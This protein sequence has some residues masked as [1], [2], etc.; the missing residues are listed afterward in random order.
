MK[1]HLAICLCLFSFHLAHAAEIGSGEIN[2]VK[3]IIDSRNY[4]AKSF[5][6]TLTL[7]TDF[8][9]DLKIPIVTFT[10]K[11]T[12][13]L[14]QNLHITFSSGQEFYKT[15]LENYCTQKLN[16]SIAQMKTKDGALFGTQVATN[17][18]WKVDRVLA[19]YKTEN[20]Q[21]WYTFVDCDI[22]N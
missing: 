12:S 1:L 6:G 17:T 9:T 7:E 11:E 22:R 14:I 18:P 10:T 20:G 19:Y 4:S 2:S 15:I 3:L 21:Q 8:R 16:V 5:K 13:N